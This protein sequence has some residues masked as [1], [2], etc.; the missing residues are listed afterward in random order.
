MDSTTWFLFELNIKIDVV[1]ILVGGNKVGLLLI[2]HC[3]REQNQ[4]VD[5]LEN[6]R[7]SQIIFSLLQRTNP[8]DC[9]SLNEVINE[10]C[11]GI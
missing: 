7:S 1:R 10:K 9:E 2:L 8:S 5:L 3:K 4:V 6:H 11:K